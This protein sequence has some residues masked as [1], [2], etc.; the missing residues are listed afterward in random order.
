MFLMPAKLRD[1]HY[2]LLVCEED[3]EDTK[4]KKLK[5]LI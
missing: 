1:L 3:N 4:K 2:S 5:R